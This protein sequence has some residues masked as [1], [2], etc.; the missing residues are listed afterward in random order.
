M[1]KSYKDLKQGN[2]MKCCNCYYYKK[3]SISWCTC[4]G[5]SLI[6]RVVNV[7]I[8]CTE[9]IPI[10]DGILGLKDKSRTKSVDGEG[11]A[12]KSGAGGR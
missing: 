10:L 12:R 4:F 11:Q 2:I 7:G 6:G 9:Y 1:E 8:K 3:D 5:T